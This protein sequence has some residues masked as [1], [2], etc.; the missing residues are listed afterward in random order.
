MQAGSRLQAFELL[1]SPS[2]VWAVMVVET[3]TPMQQC[4]T[5]GCVGYGV[6]RDCPSNATRLHHCCSVR[7][8]TLVAKVEGNLAC[9]LLCL[10]LWMQSPGTWVLLLEYSSTSYAPL[11]MLILPW[12]GFMGFPCLRDWQCTP[13]AGCTRCGHGPFGWFTGGVIVKL[14]SFR[15]LRNQHIHGL[16]LQREGNRLF[17]CSP[18]PA[19][20]GGPPAAVRSKASASFR[21]HQKVSSWEEQEDFKMYNLC[22][23]AFQTS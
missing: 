22:L 18:S 12:G 11:Q 23:C 20:H 13:M 14:L 17:S 10:G 21:L 5:I 15:V 7:S 16:G 3:A 6:G 2:C 19:F 9:F 1:A 4:C 8:L